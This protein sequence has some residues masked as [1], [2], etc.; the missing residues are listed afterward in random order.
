MLHHRHTHHIVYFLAALIALLSLPSRAEDPHFPTQILN[1]KLYDSQTL[2]DDKESQGFSV[3]PTAGAGPVW[4]LY[5]YVGQLKD[6][7]ESAMTSFR[8]VPE[9]VQVNPNE[10]FV[11]FESGTMGKPD[12]APSLALSQDPAVAQLIEKDIQQKLQTLPNA[13]TAAINHIR[14]QSIAQYYPKITSETL[15]LLELARIE[16]M[17][18]LSLEVIVGQ[19][20]VPDVLKHFVKQTNGG[21]IQ[22]NKNIF[23]ILIMLIT[24]G[25]FIQR[26]V[27]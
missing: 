12:T 27:L 20:D 5:Y 15:M 11:R 22:R 17:Q 18:P 25:F 7:D 9:G 16:N 19:G 4:I 26:Y 24:A 1:H 23:L 3:R 8:V 14:Y 13:S 10:M 21:W 2:Q 6:E